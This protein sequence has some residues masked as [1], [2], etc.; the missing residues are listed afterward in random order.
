MIKKMKKMTIYYA[1]FQFLLSKNMWLKMLHK[2]FKM[3]K[4]NS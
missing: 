1:I 4:N 3:I 2:Y